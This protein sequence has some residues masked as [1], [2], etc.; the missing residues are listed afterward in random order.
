MARL[1]IE[2]GVFFFS[3]FLAVTAQDISYLEELY[4]Q[5]A[6]TDTR[7]I[8]GSLYQDAF[9]GSIGHPFFLSENWY[10]GEL[11]MMG[12]AYHDLPLKYD[13]HRDLLLYNHIL[14]S[15]SY[16]LVLNTTRID[17]FVIDGHTF[18][19]LDRT[20]GDQHETDEGFYE[21]ILAGKASFYQKWYKRYD[22]PSQHARG[23]FSE[24]K[25][26][27]ILNDNQCF[28]VSRR[29]GLLQA[30]GDREKEIRSYIRENRIVVGSADEQ[31]V[32]RVIDY[33]NSLQ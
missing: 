23:E 26:W 10:Y 31:A 28:Q 33:Y 3:G 6:G 7:F 17:T 25:E 20:P 19:K 22:E 8:N 4:H 32:K 1:A 30:L 11:V 5:S 18:C 27:Y 16:V 29:P 2:I 15:G 13:L 21:L 9:P 12:R 14:K 24:F